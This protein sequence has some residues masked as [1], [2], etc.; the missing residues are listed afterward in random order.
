MG[1]SHQPCYGHWEQDRTGREQDRTG[2]EQ[3]RTG[4]NHPQAVLDIINRDKVTIDEAI[5]RF[6]NDYFDSDVSKAPPLDILRYFEV[7][8]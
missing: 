3:D 2:R 4:R 6:V 5:S 1:I 7:F 8:C